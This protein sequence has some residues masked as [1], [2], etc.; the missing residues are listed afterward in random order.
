MKINLDAQK[1][2]KIYGHG[3]TSV[4]ALSAVSLHIVEGEVA[5]VMGSSGSGKT[6]LLQVIGTLMKPTSGKISVKGVDITRLSEKDLPK[7]RIKNLGFVFQSPNLLPSLTALE[8]VEIALNLAGVKGKKARIEAKTRLEKLG[9]GK[10]LDHLPDK[11]SGGEQQRVAI[12]RALANNPPIILADEPTANLD[13]KNGHV[14]VGLLRKIAKKEGKSVIV[15]THDPRIRKFADHVLWLE[16]GK[17]TSKRS[18]GMEIDPICLMFVDKKSSDYSH[19]FKNRKYYFCS[20]RCKL[21][22]ERNPAK[23][24]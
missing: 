21:E 6:T 12:A 11:L 14:I 18:P 22:F 7:I 3:R 23:Y 9:L 19:T 10:R 16:D 13:S 8:N 17:L 1:L 24:R 15:V 20:E 2:T 5:I 4:M